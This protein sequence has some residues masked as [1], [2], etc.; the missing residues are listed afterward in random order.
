M[1]ISCYPIEYGML[2]VQDQQERKRKA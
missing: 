2:E 1:G